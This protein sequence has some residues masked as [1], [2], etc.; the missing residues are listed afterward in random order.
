MGAASTD[1][2]SGHDS[3]NPVENSPDES[4]TDIQKNNASEESAVQDNSA[5]IVNQKPG[6]GDNSSL[7]KEHSMGKQKQLVIKLKFKAN[8]AP[9]LLPEN[10]NIDVGPLIN[11]TQEFTSLEPSKRP[12]GNTCIEPEPKDTTKT[13]LQS[14]GSNGTQIKQE[15]QNSDTALDQQPLIGPINDSC[16]TDT[17]KDNTMREDYAVLGNIG[18]FLELSGPAMHTSFV[19][20][21]KDEYQLPTRE[22]GGDQSGEEGDEIGHLLPNTTSTSGKLPIHGG[23]ANTLKQE[24]IAIDKDQAFNVNPS[25]AEPG[26][27]D[28]FGQAHQPYT[29]S[30]LF[31]KQSTSPRPTNQHTINQAPVA[32]GF[33]PYNLPV[34]PRVWNQPLNQSSQSESASLLEHQEKLQR[35]VAEKR[36]ELEETKKRFESHGRQKL[37]ASGRSG[38]A[39]KYSSVTPAFAPGPL[40]YQRAPSTPYQPLAYGNIG[41][42]ATYPISAPGTPYGQVSSRMSQP[43]YTTHGYSMA[44]PRDASKRNPCLHEPG[45]SKPRQRFPAEDDV[46]EEESDYDDDDEPLRRRTQH[47]SDDDGDEASDDDEP[48]RTRVKRHPSVMSQDSV[49]HVQSSPIANIRGPHNDDSDVEMIANR[50]TP[51]PNNGPKYKNPVRKSRPLPQPLRALNGSSSDHGKGV[52]EG[53]EDE[54]DPNRIDWSLPRYELQPQPTINDLPSTKISLPGLVRE[55]LLL[56]PD[57]SAQETHL[58]LHLFLPG[59]QALATPD[60]EPA[61]AVLNF[62]TIAVMVIECFVQYEI[63]D[64]L[65]L[66][67]GHFH[68]RHDDD[69]EAEYERVRDARDASVEEIFFAVVDRWR[70]GLESKKEALQLIRGAQEFCDHALDVIYYIKEHGLLRQKSSSNNKGARKER[71]EEE[72]VGVSRK[73]KSKDKPAAGGV[74]RGTVGKPN[75]VGARKK[76]K[77]EV[78]KKKGKAAVPGLVVVKKR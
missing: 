61:A 14:S 60:P 17:L 30:M 76:A 11:P 20:D 54:D 31:I 44:I 57:H 2:P 43:G 67:R 33:S 37:Q 41:A 1:N 25:K 26:V 12:E 42:Q 5:S 52:E 34:I 23:D 7:D 38:H 55:E 58:L 40:S 74:K 10:A 32:S 49:I 50:E 66:G 59:Q 73:G 48:L 75:Q 21:R 27:G 15:Y 70:A 6:S 29:G 9:A 46:E 4:S 51:E 68:D 71:T 35:Q 63:G 62:H 45:P 19:T 22:Q 53:D 16:L 65:G 13:S 8:N 18:T 39:Q 24:D 64:E 3:R 28:I 36:R 78:V 77:V 56:S 69:A 72:M 47:L